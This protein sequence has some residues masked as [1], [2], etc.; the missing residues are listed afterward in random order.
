MSNIRSSASFVRITQS[1]PVLR[2]LFE[3]LL[4]CRSDD[5][6]DI[7]GDGGCTGKSALHPLVTE[8][9]CLELDDRASGRKAVLSHLDRCS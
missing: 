4:E 2:T 5:P 9:L 7:T 1:S 6:D 3:Y 8:I